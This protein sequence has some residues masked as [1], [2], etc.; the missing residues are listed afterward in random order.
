MPAHSK[1]LLQYGT[2]AIAIHPQ[3]HG[4]SCDRVWRTVIVAAMAVMLIGTTAFS[5]TDISFADGKRK[6]DN[7]MI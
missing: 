3:K 7:K 2:D 4:N 6:Y 1:R 5:T